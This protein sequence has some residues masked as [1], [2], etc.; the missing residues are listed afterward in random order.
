MLKRKGYLRKQVKE[1]LLE[2]LGYI[3]DDWIRQRE[4]V[5]K[6]IDP[7]ENVL[8]ELKKAEVKYFFLLREAKVLFSDK[9][10]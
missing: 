5:E 4:I 3:K 7:S 10:S 2:D 1:L 8:Y 9:P 6:S